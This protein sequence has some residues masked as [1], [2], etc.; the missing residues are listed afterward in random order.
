MKG[1]THRFLNN[2]LEGTR[3][4]GTYPSAE[5]PMYPP[6]APVGTC[7]FWEVRLPSLFLFNFRNEVLTQE[8]V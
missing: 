6:S 5:K 1:A 7:E 4:E 2:V 8:V 3:L